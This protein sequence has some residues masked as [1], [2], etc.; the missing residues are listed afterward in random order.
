MTTGGLIQMT[1]PMPPRAGIK[2]VLRHGT[3][4]YFRITAFFSDEIGFCP[5]GSALLVKQMICGAF[6]L[7]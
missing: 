4:S 6:L 5:I 1:M 3:Y 7:R 2:G